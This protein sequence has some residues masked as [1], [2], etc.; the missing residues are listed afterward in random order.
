MNFSRKLEGIVYTCVGR[1]RARDANDARV[2]GLGFLL[3]GLY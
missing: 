3:I 2:R 1:N